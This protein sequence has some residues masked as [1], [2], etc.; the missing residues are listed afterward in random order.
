MSPCDRCLSLRLTALLIVQLL[1]IASAANRHHKAI[2]V[3]TASNPSPIL[4]RYCRKVVQDVTRQSPTRSVRSLLRY[5]AMQSL[6]R[7]VPVVGG[8]IAA[9]LP[10]RAVA[11]SP[12]P[13]K[14][15][16]NSP[17]E[18]TIR[19]LKFWR[20]VGPVVLHY[21]FT[22]LWFNLVHV[23]PTT[24]SQTWNQLHATH[25]PASLDVILEL[26]GLFVKIGQV[27]SSRADF[28]PR[29]YV[30][31]FHTLQDAVPPWDTEIVEDIVR[32]SLREE[33]GLEMEDVLE[34][35]LGEVLGR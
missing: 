30:D 25:A 31:C 23:D 21:K 19:A 5:S 3:L 34:D 15:K 35:G 24:R 10:R 22:Q 13:S 18:P 11:A 12:R 2:C 14:V 28:V 1:G 16:K 33:H 8:C 20:K 26:R 29:Q 27:M 9:S 6:P 7:S 17:L 32:E 4:Y